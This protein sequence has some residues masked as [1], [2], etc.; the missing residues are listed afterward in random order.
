MTIEHTI[1]V[2]LSKLIAR[3][4]KGEQGYNILISPKLGEQIIDGTEAFILADVFN[5]IFSKEDQL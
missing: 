2:N 4:V 1:A 5:S 3:A